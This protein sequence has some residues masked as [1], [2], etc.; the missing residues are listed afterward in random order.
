[1]DKTKSGIVR[2]S[3]S[4]R[5]PGRT[6][7]DR[8][9]ALTDADIEQAVAG[10]PDAAAALDDAWLDRAKLVG[11]KKLISIRLDLD[12]LGFFQAQGE[13]YQTRI[14]QVLRAYVDLARDRTSA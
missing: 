10:D 11:Q 13:G 1:M 8:V 4:E 6:D 7:W 14:N 12:V 3:L 2:R 5:R 9:R